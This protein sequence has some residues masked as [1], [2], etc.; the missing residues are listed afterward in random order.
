VEAV[1]IS[2]RTGPE[3]TVTVE[4][5][6]LETPTGLT[7]TGK[8]FGIRLDLTYTRTTLF[9]VCEIWASETNDRSTA[10][11][12]RD[13][14]DEKYIYSAEPE[15]T[16]YFWIR[17]RDVFDNVSGWYPDSSTAGVEGSA[18]MVDADNFVL[19]AMTEGAVFTSAH[20]IEGNGAFQAWTETIEL[21]IAGRI[22]VHL[23]YRQGYKGGVKQTGGR[24]RINGD[25]MNSLGYLGHYQD[26]I[27][28]HASRVCNPGTIP[29]SIEWY[30]EDST[31]EWANRVMI[32]QVFKRSS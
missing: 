21:E 9:E 1:D 25:V 2:G 27:A 11:M 20:V 31:V 3:G 17:T 7:A 6:D 28:Y 4:I 22:M 12:I 19:D 10:L 16:H 30:A 14:D 5:E 8:P 24:I 26:V 32:V 13:T 18:T 29:I 23:S 15:D